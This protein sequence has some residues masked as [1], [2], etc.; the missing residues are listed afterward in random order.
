[1]PVDTAAAVSDRSVIG[2]QYVNLIPPNGN[3]PYLKGGET[4]PMSRTSIPLAAETL[5]MNMDSLVT[6]VD[7]KSLRITVSEL[8]KAFSNRG[9][10]PR[11]PARLAARP[12]RPRPSRTCRRRSP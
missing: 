6:S 8:G 7:L 5:L 9:P 12:A 3:A 4:I 1:M 2:E 11:Q 10:G